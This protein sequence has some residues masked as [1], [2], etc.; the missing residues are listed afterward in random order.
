M[1]KISTIYD[2]LLSS[3]DTLFP[4]GSSYTRI[5]DVYSVENNSDVY[6]RKGYGL[7]IES[8][9]MLVGED[10]VSMHNILFSPVVT[11]IFSREIIEK[12]DSPT[13]KDSAIK[14]ILEDINTIATTWTD[15]NEVS[16]AV[17]NI[18]PQASNISFVRPEKKN[19]IFCEVNFEVSYTEK[20]IYK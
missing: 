12:A 4:S 5:P 3:L 13:S 10:G 15:H 7:R 20:Y 18:L 6:T 11:V 9:G 19:F 1:S 2:S 17:V 14:S 16:D 8:T